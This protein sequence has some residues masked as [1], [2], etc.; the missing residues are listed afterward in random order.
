LQAHT[1]YYGDWAR[2]LDP[3]G[4]YE[5]FHLGN[6]GPLTIRAQRD[7]DS[8]NLYC[9]LLASVDPKGNGFAQR[10]GYFEM[11]AKLP[12]GLGTWPAFWLEDTVGLKNNSMGH[13]EIDILE[14]YGN[15]VASDTA[16]HYPDLYPLPLPLS[17]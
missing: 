13:H 1:P 6:G 2:F 10:Y 5:P 14:A 9:G 17:R 3:I 7:G 4:D 8:N 11:R 12:S 15:N 16:S